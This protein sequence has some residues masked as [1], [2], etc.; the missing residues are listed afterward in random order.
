MYKGRI[1]IHYRSLTVLIILLKCQYLLCFLNVDPVYEGFKESVWVADQHVFFS[2]LV[3]DESVVIYQIKRNDPSY[4]YFAVL[5]CCC[6][7]NNNNNNNK[8][9]KRYVSVEVYKCIGCLVRS[10]LL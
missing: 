1:H 4:S 7:L 8:P 10:Y 9:H 5:F 2:V 6:F 3:L